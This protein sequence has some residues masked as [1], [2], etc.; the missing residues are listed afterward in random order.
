[1]QQF[2][3]TDAYSIFNLSAAQSAMVNC[4]SAEG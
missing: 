3:P 2:K 1:M 4:I